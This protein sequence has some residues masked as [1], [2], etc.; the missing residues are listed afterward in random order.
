MDQR[1][2]PEICHQINNYRS[3]IDRLLYGEK[4][5]IVAI[6]LYIPDDY[7]YGNYRLYHLAPRVDVESTLQRFRQFYTSTITQGR[8]N[9]EIL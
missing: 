3:T 6:Y 9:P 4:R 8:S 7:V 5:P 1:L 2:P